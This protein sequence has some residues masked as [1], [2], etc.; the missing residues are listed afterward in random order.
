MR[1]FDH[2]TSFE[3]GFSLD[4]NPNFPVQVNGGNEMVIIGHC[5]FCKQA[6]WRG[7]PHKCLDDAKEERDWRLGL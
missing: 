7:V 2:L 5:K 4:L 3:K 1:F 6:V